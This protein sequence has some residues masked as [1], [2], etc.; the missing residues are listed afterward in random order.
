MSKY[1]IRRNIAQG[2]VLIEAVDSTQVP[3]YGSRQHKWSNLT[4]VGVQAAHICC[5]EMVKYLDKLEG[6]D[7]HGIQVSEV[8]A[9]CLRDSS[10]KINRQMYR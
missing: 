6:V 10:K 8:M 4:R 7:V 1:R 2:W 9:C 3:D 5:V